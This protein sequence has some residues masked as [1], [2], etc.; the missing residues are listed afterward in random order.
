M[1]EYLQRRF[2]GKRIQLFIA[3]LYL[4]IYVFTKISVSEMQ[5]GKIIM[6]QA[7]SQT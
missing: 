2:G 3:V 5:K 7:V 4:F 1:P 6:I